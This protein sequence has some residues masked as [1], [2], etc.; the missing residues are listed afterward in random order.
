MASDSSEPQG[1]E[2]PEP[3]GSKSVSKDEGASTDEKTT[4]GRRTPD[5]DVAVLRAKIAQVVWVVCVVLALFLA[6]GAL[7][8]ALGANENNGLVS[9]V[10]SMADTAGL[11]VFSL[12]DGIK[13]FD[14]ENAE[15]KNALFN[16]GLGAIF[17][18]ILG[19]VLDR[20]IR[21]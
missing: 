3:S 5:I 10:L 20:V 7:C 11:G 9:F 17:W 18:L 14:G 19:R 6:V 21:P 1:N 12:E 4:G 8:I 15:I 16:W 13:T 2:A